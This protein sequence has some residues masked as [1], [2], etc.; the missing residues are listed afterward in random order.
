MFSKQA[1]VE[2]VQSKGFINIGVQRELGK[3]DGKG[4]EAIQ[5]S[6]FMGGPTLNLGVCSAPR[7]VYWAFMLLHLPVRSYELPEG[8][9][10][11]GTFYALSG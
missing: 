11:L 2:I 9:G 4:K 6:A 8:N 1:Q 7:E 5:G 3:Q 10:L